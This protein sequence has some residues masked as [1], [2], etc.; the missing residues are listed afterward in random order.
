MDVIK[1]VPHYVKFLKKLYTKKYKPK[2]NKVII[3]GEKVSTILQRK[4]PKCKD[5]GSFT[6]P[7]TISNT[8]FERAIL[9][10]GSFINVMPYSIYTSLNLGEFKEIGVVIQLTNRSNVYLKGILED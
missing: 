9:D 3:I 5:P 10:L 6:I 2:G 7:C 8:R 4:P 1:Q